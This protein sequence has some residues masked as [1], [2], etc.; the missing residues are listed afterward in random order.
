[1][2]KSVFHGVP[3]EDRITRRG[4]GRSPDA[5]VDYIF[6]R[7]SDFLAG[8]RVVTA[9]LSG[10]FP[11]ACETIVRQA[12]P[13]AKVPMAW[14]PVAQWQSISLALLLVLFLFCWWWVLG[15][16]QFYSPT[17][18]ALVEE[19]GSANLL[20][21]PEGDEALSRLPDT[22]DELEADGTWLPARARTDAARSI[23][24]SLEIREAAAKKNDRKSHD[25]VCEER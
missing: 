13:A 23:K 17:L 25:L 15:R 20:S 19:G 24:Q 18:T 11:V 22:V 5:T 1:G 10:H 21:Y 6:A 12:A 16:K 9:D 4:D 7:N 2:C 3:L 8:P 14:Q